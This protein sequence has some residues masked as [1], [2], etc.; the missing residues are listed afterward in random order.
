MQ[1][2]PYH[3]Y[4]RRGE[5]HPC[6]HL[7]LEGQSQTEWQAGQQ[8]RAIFDLAK[9]NNVTFVAGADPS[10]GASGGWVMVRGEC[11]SDDAN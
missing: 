3:C 1:N 6:S 8:F 11:E 4:N 9:E 5:Y 7:N 10:V 2:Q